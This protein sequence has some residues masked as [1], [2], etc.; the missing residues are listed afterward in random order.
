MH[1]FLWLPPAPYQLDV[2]WFPVRCR[3]CFRPIPIPVRLHSQVPSLPCFQLP[4]TSCKGYHYL[5][6]Q[7]NYNLPRW[8]MC[9][10]IE[11]KEFGL[12]VS[13]FLPALICLKLW[14][15]CF[16]LLIIILFYFPFLEAFDFAQRVDLHVQFPAKARTANENGGWVWNAAICDYGRFKSNFIRSNEAVLDTLFVRH[17]LPRKKQAVTMKVEIPW[18]DT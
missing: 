6:S 9:W 10:K 16:P 15:I 11:H 7:P 1:G 13:V 5:S 8:C 2:F 14:T 3:S 18:N 4:V 17:A 12:A